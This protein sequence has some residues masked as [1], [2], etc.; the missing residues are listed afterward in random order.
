[1]K[2]KIIRIYLK[3]FRELKKQV[4]PIKNETMANYFQRLVERGFK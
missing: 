4:P 2:T 3:T 1:M